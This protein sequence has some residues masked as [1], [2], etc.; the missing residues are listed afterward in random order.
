[1]PVI[2]MTLGEDQI[3]LQQKNEFIQT[4]TKSASAITKIPEQSF[5]V[6]IEQLNCDNIG[7]GGISLTEKRK[8]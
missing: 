5:I 2:T 3:D 1:M 8:L 6:F 4:V 7:V